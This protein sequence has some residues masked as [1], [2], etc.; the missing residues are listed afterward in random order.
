MH[1]ARVLAP[2]AAVS[3]GWMFLR[4]SIEPIENGNE[5]RIPEFLFEDS[6]VP[7]RNAVA[8]TSRM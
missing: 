6:I 7:M 2:L 4:D 5:L 8:D 1:K 3:G